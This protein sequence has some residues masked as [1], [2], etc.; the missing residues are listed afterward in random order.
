[1][2]THILNCD[3]C[4][5]SGVGKP[6]IKIIYNVKKI[7]RSDMLPL[8]EYISTTYE[9]SAHCTYCCNAQ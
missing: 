6:D 7:F 2:S 8:T 1:M 4:D 5:Y 3:L 9:L